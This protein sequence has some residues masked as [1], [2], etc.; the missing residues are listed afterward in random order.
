MLFQYAHCKM[1]RLRIACVFR[2][3]QKTRF[4]KL[5]DV[6][7]KSNAHMTPWRQQTES[8][9]RKRVQRFVG[10]RG[11]RRRLI[12]FVRGADDIF[13]SDFRRVPWDRKR[14]AALSYGR[15]GRCVV[16]SEVTTLY[17]I[18]VP[19][20]AR[21]S[22]TQRITLSV[23]VPITARFVCRPNSFLDSSKIVT[24]W[25]SRLAVSGLKEIIIDDKQWKVC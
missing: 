20:L 21:I 14:N 19:A 24:C 13:C 3:W 15:A 18:A 11:R 1:Y 6:G 2:S 8:P 4:C 17:R 9:C 22:Y 12:A 5:N 7:C 10:I 25:T 16:V 23:A